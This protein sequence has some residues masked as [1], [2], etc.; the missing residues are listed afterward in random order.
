MRRNIEEERAS[1]LEEEKMNPMQ[2]MIGLVILIVVVFIFCFAVWKI[3][4]ANRSGPLPGQNV[5]SSQ[6]SIVNRTSQ[7]SET[8]STE[9]SEETGGE[10]SEES[11][12]ENALG[13]TF[14]AVD[15]YVTA[16]DVT[17]LRSEPSTDQGQLTV[18]TQLSNGQNARRTGINP[19]TGWSRLEYNGQVVYAVSQYLI[20]AEME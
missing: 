18:V 3:T 8:G 12:P 15:E 16:K 2:A 13:M 10:S 1:T 4:H 9:S 14:D 6:D 7:P 20:V 19:N 5:D 17:N 11:E